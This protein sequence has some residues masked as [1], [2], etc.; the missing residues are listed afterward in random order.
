LLPLLQAFCIAQIGTFLSP[1]HCSNIAFYDSS[2]W[3]SSLDFMAPPL[4]L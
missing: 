4:L 3:Q 1:S 2:N